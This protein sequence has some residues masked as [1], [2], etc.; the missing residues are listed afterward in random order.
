MSAAALEQELTGSGMADP[1]AVK[2]FYLETVTPLA[3][4]NGLDKLPT[5]RAKNSQQRSVAKN[6]TYWLSRRSFGMPEGYE[7][8][9]WKSQIEDKTA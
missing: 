2:E 5:V 3:R 9:K 6:Q 8:I 4:R 1:T 7:R